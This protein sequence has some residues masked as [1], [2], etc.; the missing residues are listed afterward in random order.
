[1]TQAGQ[2]PFPLEIAGIDKFKFTPAGLKFNSMKVNLI[3]STAGEKFIFTKINNRRQ[4]F[5]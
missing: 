5:S 4:K 3:H 1:M 2:S